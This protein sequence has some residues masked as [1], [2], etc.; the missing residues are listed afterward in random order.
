MER[1]LSAMEKRM[2]SCGGSGGG[3]DGRVSGWGREMMGRD[4]DQEANQVVKFNKGLGRAFFVQTKKHPK[5]ARQALP[6][7]PG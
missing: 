7:S 5:Q 2:S 3:G 1:W 6:H 4:S